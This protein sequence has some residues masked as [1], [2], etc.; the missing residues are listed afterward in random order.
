M[1]GEREKDIMGG[2]ETDS[3]RVRIKEPK[4]IQSET[5]REREGEREIESVEELISLK[6]YPEF[7]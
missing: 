4:E 7:I 6:P 2:R 5:E 3:Q 1:K